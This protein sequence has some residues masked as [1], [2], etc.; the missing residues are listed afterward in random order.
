[1]AEEIVKDVVGDIV[2][3][4]DGNPQNNMIGALTS[5]ILEHMCG[6]ETEIS[7]KHSL[8]LMNLKCKKMSQYEDFHRDW[9]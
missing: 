9:V 1:M 7:G 5:F 3:N 6:A 4:E 2:Y 8:V